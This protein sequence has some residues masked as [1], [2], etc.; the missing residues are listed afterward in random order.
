MKL[1][2]I[3][4][5]VLLLVMGLSAM[6]QRKQ[7]DETRFGLMGGVNISNV[8]TGDLDQ[9]KVDSKAGFHAGMFVDMPLIGVVH[10][11]PELLYTQRGT[12]N[13]IVGSGIIT[14]I[15]TK[16]NYV[17]L[18]LELSVRIPVAMLTVDAIVGPYASFGINGKTTVKNHIF[19][20]YAFSDVFEG[21]LS[22]MDTE[23]SDGI[24]KDKGDMKAAYKRLDF[25]LRFGAGVHLFRRLG[26]SA[27]YDLGF[28]DIRKKEA[29]EVLGTVKDELSAKNGS[30]QISC[31][32]A[33]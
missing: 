18:P 29:K 26:V 32:V 11:Q 25:G 3:L 17:Q 15:E 5:V 30:F 9:V 28:L 8:R 19:G 33:F 16:L 1:K 22:W 31:S 4:C 14:D 23:T 7:K 24:F 2:S 21:D 10:F 20:N 6:A 27:Y 13:R 12:K